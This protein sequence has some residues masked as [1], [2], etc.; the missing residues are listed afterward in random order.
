VAL[1]VDDI[2]K[3]LAWYRDVVGF[4]VD[5]EMEEDGQLQLAVLLAGQVEVLLTQDDGAKGRDRS[6]GVGLSLR[7][8]TAQDIDALAERIRGRGGEL[9]AE[10]ADMP[11]GERIFR[12]RDPDGFTYTVV[13]GSDD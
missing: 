6:K 3:S 11:W 9:L 13:A 5:R 7:I 4:H 12:I 8:T 10:P 1:T 2:Q